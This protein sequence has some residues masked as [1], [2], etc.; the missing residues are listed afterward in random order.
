MKLSKVLYLSAA[1]ALASAPFSHVSAQTADVIHWWTSGSESKAVKVFA[2]E[3]EKR[4]GKWIDNAVVGGQPAQALAMSR[5]AGGQAPAALMWNVGVAVRKLAEQGI[6]TDLDAEAK[7][8]GWTDKIPPLIAKNASYQGHVVAVPVDIHADNWLWYST[9]VLADAGVEPP[10]TFDEMIASADKIKA[11]G[12]IPLAV[13]GEPWQQ[14]LLFRSV[15]VGVGGKAFYK[16]VMIDHDADA[17]AGPDMVKSFDMLRRL[18]PLTDEG[19]AGRKWNDTAMLVA[20]NKAAF[21]I[22]GDWVKG[23]FKAAGLTPGKE[24]GCQLSPGNQDAYIM[25]V[26]VFVFPKTDDPDKQKGQVL[27][28]N[29]MMDPAVQVAFNKE[30]GAIPP[31]LDA[32]VGTLD[33]CSQLGKKVVS[34]EDNQLPN[35]ALAV[36][37]DA[38]GQMGDLVA[39]FWSDPSMTSQAAAKSFADIVANDQ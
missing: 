3:F 32:D 23:E 15:M 33:M 5:I 26:D 27:L 17:A 1:F 22:M 8:G 21:Q 19:M 24:F 30:K 29:T 6:L 25:T 20:S 4:G 12:Y 7:A 37:A 2:S 11:K 10:K 39:Q 36:S 16:K 18:K 28:A 9:K 31:R 34:V 13:G 35:A 38:E 14:S